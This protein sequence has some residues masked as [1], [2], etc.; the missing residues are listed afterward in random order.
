MQASKFLEFA[1]AVLDAATK[2]M[3]GRRRGLLSI[4]FQ[5]SA[6][7]RRR[8]RVVRKLGA[9]AVLVAAFLELNGILPGRQ[10]LCLL[11]GMH[12]VSGLMLICFYPHIA[13]VNNTL[14]PSH[15]LARSEQRGLY[16]GGVQFVVCRLIPTFEHGQA[17][18][19]VLA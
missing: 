14:A 19:G 2:P 13:P 1:P 4:L 9:S 18:L 10:K 5:L 15:K 6:E 3:S 11:A 8:A 12:A 16:L 7:V 17:N